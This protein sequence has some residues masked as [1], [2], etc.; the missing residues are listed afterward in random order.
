MD[1]CLCVV[2]A[3]ERVCEC[4]QTGVRIYVQTLLGEGQRER[5]SPSRKVGVGRR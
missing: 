1:L 3:G 2:C 5:K 4:V